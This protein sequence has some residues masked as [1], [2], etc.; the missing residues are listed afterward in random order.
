MVQIEIGE[1]GTRGACGKTPWVRQHDI[2][3]VNI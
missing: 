1:S 3:E 2:D